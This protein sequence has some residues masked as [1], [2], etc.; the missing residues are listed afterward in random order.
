MS[1]SDADYSNTD[2]EYRAI[3]DFLNNLSTKNPFMMWESGRMNFWRYS[4]HAKKERQDPFFRDNVHVW[5]D[6]QRIIGLCISEYGRN[7]LF[8]EVLP[9]YLHIYPEIFRWVE[10][11]WG[12]TRE[13][14]EVDVF[15]DDTQ[16]I[17]RLKVQGFAFMSHVENKRIYDLDQIA[18]GYHLE[19]GFTI[20]T[21][22]EFP[23][24]AGKVALVQSA[25]NNTN[26][27]DKNVK[28]L[29][30]SPD[31]ISEYDLMVISPDRQ[32]VAYCVGWHEQ[33]REHSGYIEPV[34]THAE[35]RQ[36]GFAKAVI[37]ECFARMKANDIRTV[38]IASSAEPDISNFLYDSLSPQTKREVHKY[39]KK[40]S[41]PSDS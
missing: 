3:C 38:E 6:G 25:F 12:N 22:S 32:P 14:I 40:V 4:V 2:K 41:S 34:G 15:G 37:R 20:Q 5:R 19:A 29:T 9:E 39:Q 10:K 30:A 36:R 27:S 17:N 7:D 11:I 18:L 8:I 26:Y 28:R 23:D 1:I 16:K 21:F 31:Y 33:A 35:Y 24:Y 13:L